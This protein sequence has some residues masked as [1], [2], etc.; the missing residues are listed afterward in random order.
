VGEHRQKQ[1]DLVAS[2][3]IIT[4]NHVGRGG[5]ETKYSSQEAKGTNRTKETAWITKCLYYI[6]KGFWKKGSSTPGLE[7]SG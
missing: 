1:T 5:K 2:R 3:V 4:P 7:S 6:R